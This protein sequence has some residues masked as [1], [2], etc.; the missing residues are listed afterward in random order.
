[1]SE[2]CRNCA[3]LTHCEIVDVS[4][5]NDRFKC[6]AYEAAP[7]TEVVANKFVTRTFGAWALGY[8]NKPLQDRK[9]REFKTSKVRRRHHNG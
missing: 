7:E 2:N 3:Y 8:D 9:A 5:L 4:K 6:D 1:M